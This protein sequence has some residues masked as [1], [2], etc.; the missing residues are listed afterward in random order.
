[1]TPRS[2]FEAEDG[3]S[4]VE[5][6][7]AI[8]VLGLIMGAM[9]QTLV[10]SLQ[11]AQAQERQ[12]HATSLTRQLVEEARGLPWPKLGLCEDDI[13]AVFPGGT[14]DYADGS[15]EVLVPIS[16]QDEIC[17]GV[18]DPPLQ[19]RTTIERNG[20][21]YTVTTVVTWHDDPLDNDASGNDADPEDLKRI[22]VRAD[23]EIRGQPRSTI[24]ESF[25]AEDAYAPPLVA[26]V[27]HEG[28]VNYTYLNAYD[29]DG[30]ND[31]LTQTPVVL[32][33]TAAVP[34]SGVEV[35]W[36][37]ADGSTVTRGLGSADKLVWTHTIPPGDTDFTANR[38]SNGETVFEF[39]ARE[40]ATARVGNTFARG[41]FLIEPSGVGV[42]DER[43]IGADGVQVSS[44]RVASGQTCGPYTLS[45]F[46]DGLLRSDFVTAVWTDGLGQQEMRAGEEDSTR[47]GATFSA[48]LPISPLPAGGGTPPASVTVSFF[49]QRV[50]DGLTLGKEPSTADTSSWDPNEPF[51]V[52]EVASCTG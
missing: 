29:G 26:E 18:G 1:M 21:A 36:T 10:G 25:V 30:T 24:I 22:L 14:Y 23:W 35:T 15:S 5:V 9:A 33:V 2:K 6:L 46:V 17:A 12:V 7:V 37:N 48:T 38:L 27:L 47:M 20:V 41:L 19:P 8:L 3:I 39:T 49:L 50:G 52:T 16:M 42:R 45:I 44:V 11:S 31:G 32:R 28:G 4:L 51:A 40:A 13:P 34:Q 43:L